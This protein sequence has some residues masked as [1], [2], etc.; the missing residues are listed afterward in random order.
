MGFNAEKNLFN[1]YEKLV[2]KFDEMLALQKEDKKII[3]ELN[4]NIKE[5]HNIVKSKDETNA[6]L[7]LEI[8][9]LKN[10]INKDSNNSSKPPSSDS[11]K[12]GKSGPNLYNSREKTNRKIGGQRGHKGHSLTKAKVEQMINDNNLLVK[13]FNHHIHGKESNEIIKYKIGI[14]IIPYV[15]KHIFKCDPLHKARLPK[16]FYSEV[17]YHESVKSLCIHL[18]AYNVVA[19]ERMSDFLNV[20]TKGSI[21]VS[22]GTLVNFLRE[23]SK[24]STDTITNLESYLL[25]SNVLYTDETGAKHNKKKLTFRNYSNENIAIYKVSKKRGHSSIEGGNIIN[26]YTGIIVG[27]HDTALYSYGTNNS[28]CNVH[29]E[30]YLE[31]LTQN[32]LDISWPVEMKKL[33]RMMNQTKKIALCYGLERFDKLKVGEYEALFDEILELAK[34]ENKTI[35]SRYYQEKA[36]RLYRRLIKYKANHLL[37]MHEFNVPYSNNL[38]ERDLRILKTK[39]KVSGGFRSFEVA[40]CYADALTIIK[41]AKKQN[42]NPYDA[43]HSIFN[44]EK[45]FAIT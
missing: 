11:D 21:N 31:E 32:I 44:K 45:L 28:E 4:D 16:E 18:G 43:I 23:F 20:V 12:P 25:N 14:E 13:E 22:N 41:T 33:F 30:R 17:T 29:L 24:K 10:Q 8:E 39:T 7:L 35:G 2:V 27:D 42:I 1:Q 37:F 40:K 5:L 36:G 9:R 15:E 3:K 19:Y 34:T 38:S 6:K 26:R